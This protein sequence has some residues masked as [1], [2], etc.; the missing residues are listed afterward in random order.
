MTENDKIELRNKAT[1]SRR[2]MATS[3]TDPAT[4]RCHQCGELLHPYPKPEYWMQYP[5][6]ECCI[7][8]GLKICETFRKPGCVDAYLA[9]HPAPADAAVKR[10]KAISTR[11][12]KAKAA[13][14]MDERSAKRDAAAA[15]VAASM[16]G[17]RD[18]LLAVAKE[19]VE[20]Y[21][22]AVL[23]RADFAALV[24]SE[25]YEAVIWKLNGGTFFG[26]GAGDESAGTIAMRHCQAVPGVVPMWGQQGEFII[27]VKDIRCWVKYGGGLGSVLSCHF[28]FNALDLDGPFISETGYRSHFC[29]SVRGLTVDA[30]A[31]A[32]FADFLSKERRYLA[33]EYQDRRAED[34]LPAWIQALPVPARRRPAVREASDDALTVPDGFVL[35]DVVLPARQ[36]FIARKW[37]EASRP[38]IKQAIREAKKAPAAAPRLAARA[39]PL[40]D[41]GGLEDGSG[42]A[43]P[44][45]EP[46]Q[47]WKVIKVHHPC[48]EK[49]LGKI[50]V[51]TKVCPGKRS[52][53]AHDD[54]PVTYRKNRNGR[55]VVAY[56]PKCV[57]TVYGV[58]SL[59]MV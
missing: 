17:D 39:A 56:D 40:A 4:E 38:R 54:R 23:D 5:L 32:I 10:Q 26:S 46:G 18:G 36:A 57:E 34:L 42:G 55:M 8:D 22:N 47:R 12:P 15:T 20:L 30:A 16:P 3:V 45:P 28:E 13:N 9:A 50:V 6:P 27:S 11:P 2:L 43:D 44:E 51:I 59:E 29:G 25:R 21:N 37:A 58:D 19:C 52:V 31:A 14:S 49:S 7:I 35:V 41:D 48:F 53:F 1:Y 33:A 24:I